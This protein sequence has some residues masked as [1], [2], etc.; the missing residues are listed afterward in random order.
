VTPVDPAICSSV[1]RITPS[2]SP[3]PEMKDTR[4]AHVQLCAAACDIES[5]F[6]RPPDCIPSASGVK[7]S[8]MIGID[9]SEIAVATSTAGVRSISTPIWIRRV[10]GVWLQIYRA[11]V[12]LFRAQRQ[13]NNTST[14]RSSSPHESPP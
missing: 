3:F 8:I 11:G 10:K 5:P 4:I 13:E 12:R 6:S 14:Q 9:Q 7:C 2:P 1:I